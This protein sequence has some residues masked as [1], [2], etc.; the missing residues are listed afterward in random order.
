MYP[1]PD[2]RT[3][4]T[5]CLSDIIDDGEE[6]INDHYFTFQTSGSLLIKEEDTQHYFSQ[7]DFRLSKRNSLAKFQKIEHNGQRFESI[8]IC[9]DQ[10]SLKE[11]YES[12]RVEVNPHKFKNKSV[13]PISS[14]NL[15][16][17]FI[18]SYR[19]YLNLLPKDRL[20]FMSL[21]VKEII[22]LL[23]YLNPEL[24]DVLFNFS[25]PD[26]IDLEAFMNKNF[27]YNIPLNRF[28]YLT[29][30][31]LSTF[32]R[33]FEKIFKE[34]P[35]KWLLDRRLYEARFLIAEKGLKPK[36]FY[37]EIGFENL[38]HFSYAYKKK[39]NVTPLQIRS[40]LES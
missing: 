1:L 23:L 30:R 19:V 28:A 7:G 29:G 32:K 11:V 38:S 14:H 8:H 15:Y 20:Q 2:N 13:I 36:D 9:L 4:F 3:N 22:F 17:N 37:L 34:S 40:S 35:S 16:V 26:K 21:K 5:S 31:S 25:A 27:Q 33:D 12:F 39:F 18:Q 10:N 6:F 24:K